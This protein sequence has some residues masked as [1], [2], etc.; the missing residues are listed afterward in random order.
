M[1]CS[2]L[3]STVIENSGNNSL[4]IPNFIEFFAKA[5]DYFYVIKILLYNSQILNLYVITM[6]SQ[7]LYIVFRQA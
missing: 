4:L 1:Y 6:T 5:D 7:Y 2:G 3:F